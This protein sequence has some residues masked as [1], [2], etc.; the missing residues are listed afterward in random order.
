M[1]DVKDSVAYS[2]VTDFTKFNDWSPWYE[3]E[4]TAKT[5]ISGNSGQVGA[6]YSWVGKEVGLGNF[7]ITKLEP[8]TAIYQKLTFKEP[9]LAIAEN[10][11][12]F[13]QQGDSTEVT[14][15]YEGDND[16]IMAKWMG[17]AMDGMMGKDFERGLE[18]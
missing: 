7:E 18:K 13:N 2:Y 10:N 1:I 6:V 4:P 9:F 5:E 12:I 14:W 11:F 17:L 3:M 16:G 15:V 8:Y